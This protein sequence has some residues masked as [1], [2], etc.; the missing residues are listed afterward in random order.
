MESELLL[1]RPRMNRN[2]DV[3]RA[4]VFMSRILL[5]LHFLNGSLLF[6]GEQTMLNNRD[7]DV[8]L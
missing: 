7:S 4:I 6:Y 2:V 1:K 5:L 8:L 3:R